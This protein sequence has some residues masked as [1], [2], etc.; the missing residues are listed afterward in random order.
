MKT[1]LLFA[2]FVSPMGAQ[3]L[4]F[5]VG[6]YQMSL[7]R[8]TMIIL[9]LVLIISFLA[10]R[11]EYRFHIRSKNAYS[12]IFFFSWLVYAVVSVIW[13]PDKQGWLRSIFFI[14]MGLMMIVFCDI[15]LKEK[16]D[17]GNAFLSLQLGIMMQSAIGWYEIFTKNYLFLEMTKKNY[18]A[19]VL[20]PSHIPI[21]MTGNPNNFATMM[22][23]GVFIAMICFSFSTKK[24]EKIAHGFLL[25]NYLVLIM[26][27]QS[28]AN[29]VGLI[30]AFAFMMTIYIYEKRGRKG[31]VIS[32]FAGVGCILLA[33]IC[34]LT[35]PMLEP[36]WVKISSFL[37]LGGDSNSSNS[38]RFSLIKNG[39]QFLLMTFGFGVG[40]GQIEYWMLNKSVYSTGEIVNMHNWWMELLTGYGI[41]VFAGYIIF[42][43]RLFMD[44]FKEYKEKTRLSEKIIPLSLC[45]CMVGFVLSSI[46]SSSSITV[47]YL[48]VFWAIGIAYQKMT[49][50][51][52]IWNLL[53]V[54]I[55]GRL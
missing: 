50:A 31:V 8:M 3:F 32:L 11:N 19:Y 26:F 28:R 25:V 14:L 45:T 49:R 35:I 4:T 33:L 42:Y 54:Y 24:I 43:I 5:P 53:P 7:F 2:I 30:L 15:I 22:F 20:R 6:P 44:Y 13:S 27:T 46:S 18:E 23:I 9:L 16:K 36:S 34:L 51:G 47:E 41:I 52:K 1:L 17:I 12:I 48:W 21:A 55:E 10:K 40:S 37:G 39:L 38:I 29:M